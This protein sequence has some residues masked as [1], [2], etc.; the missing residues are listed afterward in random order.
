M[1]RFAT[2]V[3]PDGWEAAHRQVPDGG[4]TD[5][6]LIE[7]EAVTDGEY[8]SVSVWAEV[9]HDRG[10]IEPDWNRAGVVTVGAEAR[11]PTGYIGAVPVTAP[12][13]RAGDRITVTQSRDPQLVGR[14]F[15]IFEIGR[16]VH[17]VQRR[18][19]AQPDT[20]NEREE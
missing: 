9:Y 13:L 4:M 1:M 18:F 17:A 8:S 20:D 14:Q 10:R 11:R 5:E 2:A 12:Q 7:R 15:R 19:L 16:S 3:I 6:L